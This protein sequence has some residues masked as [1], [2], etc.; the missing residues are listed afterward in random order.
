MILRFETRD[1]QNAKRFLRKFYPTGYREC[2]ELDA[3]IAF[4]AEDV[5][6]IPDPDHHAGAIRAQPKAA[7]DRVK[8]ATSA[9]MKMHSAFTEKVAQ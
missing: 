8:L 4:V 6:R 1:P 5:I 9:L 2:D 3:V 7:A